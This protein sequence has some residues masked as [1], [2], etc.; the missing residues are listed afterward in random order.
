MLDRAYLEGLGT[1]DVVYSWGVLHH[2]GAMWLAIEN[3]IGRVETASGRL[4]V[5]LYNDQGWKSHV[6]WLVKRLYNRLP[7][8]L[9]GAFVYAVMFLTRA[10]VILSTRS[11]C[12]R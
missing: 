4:F 8:A 6:W 3:A 12:S 1:F 5:A 7:R 11:N 2:T 9:Q 10:A